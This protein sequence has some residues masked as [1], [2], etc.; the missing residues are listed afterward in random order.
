MSVYGYL[1]VSTDKQDYNSQK[2]G[3][4]GFAEKQGW[5]I[6]RYLTDDGVSG[7]KTPISAIW[8]TCSACCTRTTF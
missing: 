1:R 2:Q 3:V 6:D 5:Q 7:S 8:G 4:D